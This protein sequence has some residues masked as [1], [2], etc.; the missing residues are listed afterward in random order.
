MVDIPAENTENKSNHSLP[1]LRPL[2]VYWRKLGP[3][4]TT[5]AADDDPS[6]IAT[7]SQVGAQFQFQF[8]WLALFTTPLM[9]V[10]Q[11][12]CARLGMVTGRGLAA[13]IRRHFPRSALYVCVFLLFVANTFNIGAD[14]GAMAAAVR[15][16]IP[17]LSFNFFVIIFALLSLGLQIFVPYRLY[18]SYLKF[19]TFTLFAYVITAFTIDLPW[20]EILS[21][22]IF[23]TFTFS[24]DQILLVCAILGTTISPYLFF[25]QSSQEVEEEILSG[26]KTLALRHG[27]TVEEM[28]D[29]RVDVWSGM[30]ASNLVMFFIIAVC[31]ATLYAEGITNITSAASAAAALRP[32]A[33]NAASILFALGVVGVGLLGI[34]VLAGSVSYAV[35][36]SFGWKEGLYRRFGE[37]RA[38]YG[39][40]IAATIVG[41][42]LNFINLDPMRALIYS[43]IVNG[44]IA[45][46]LLVF[47][48][49]LSSNR[50]VMGE[51]TS[52]WRWKIVGWLSVL[53]MAVVGLASLFVIIF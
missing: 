32:L 15:L 41:L 9:I 33:G 39:V 43:A 50:K 25:W 28:K 5:G 14:F 22:T 4:F 51:F 1:G 21:H 11:E 30:V 34:P 36:E 38:F 7:Y 46:V 47:I 23:P 53:L 42:G 27:A 31:G 20:G 17:G 3:G 8:T 2:Q 37:A 18:A 24:H 52:N 10:I 35:T 49:L 12:M 44:M 16:V 48:V 19:L 29:M 26:R 45:P 6:G 13:N 40:I